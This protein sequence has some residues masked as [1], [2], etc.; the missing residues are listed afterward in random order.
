MADDCD[1]SVLS[2]S[3]QSVRVELRRRNLSTHGVKAELCRRLS[4]ALASSTARSNVTV[5]ARFPISQ[6]CVC[7]RDTGVISRK[8]FGIEQMQEKSDGDMKFGKRR[9]CDV[10]GFLVA[11]SVWVSGIDEMAA[12]WDV[13]DGYGKGSLSRSEPVYASADRM[14]IAKNGRAARQLIALEK[15]SAGS[16]KGRSREAV[17]HLQLTLV[18]AF[19]A[20][21]T[22]QKLRLVNIK[23]EPL[24]N[25]LRTWQIFCSRDPLFARTYAA[26][27][28][29]RRGGWLPRS[30]LKYGVDWVLYRMGT[31]RHSH[32]PYCVILAHEPVPL[33]PTWIRLQNK[34]RLVKN[35]A[36]SLIAARVQLS[37][38]DQAFPGSPQEAL[39][40]VQ[41]T[42]L[43]I[44]RWIS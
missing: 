42:E 15:T 40:T 17:E 23:G 41:I 30:G 33:E 35:V 38:P 6:A 9:K 4:S 28:H 32:S 3:V 5:P 13:S 19:H 8:R 31:K 16:A 39:R 18:E 1:A 24:D 36:K 34:L 29:Y 27:A 11:G 2:L 26:Y 43:T 21:F 14:G 20:A 25:E 12:L 37:V 22:A 44:D 7:K 10:T